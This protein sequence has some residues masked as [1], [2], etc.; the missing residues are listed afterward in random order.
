MIVCI[1]KLAAVRMLQLNEHGPVSYPGFGTTKAETRAML[2]SQ[3]NP[4]PTP[5]EEPFRYPRAQTTQILAD[6]LQTQLS[7]PS[8][9]QAA[10][11][12]GVPHTTLHYWQQRRQR[13]NAP[14]ERIA[15]F[16]SPAGLAFLKQFLL[17]LHLVFQQHGIA[18]IRPLC[19]F[20]ELS[21]LAP[22]VAS[23]YGSQQQLAT[24]LQQLLAQYDLEQRQALAPTMTAKDITLCE[25]ENFHGEQP[26]LVAIEPL[27][28][29]LVLETY[30]PQRDADTWNKVV[31]AALE[32]LP[33]RVIQVTS[34]LAKGLQAHARDG[35][36][37]QHTPDLMHV[38][39][40]LHK[41]TSLPLHRYLENA[42]E[43]LPQ[44]QEKVQHWEERYRLHQ[45]NIRSP[46]RSPDFEQSLDWARKARQ[47]WEQQVAERQACQEEVQAAVRGLGDD[48]HP[49]DAQTGQAVSVEQMQ[50]RLEQRFDTIE[51][52]AD[53][54]G[55]PDSGREK[56]AKAR[57]VSCPAWCGSGTAFACWW[58]RWIWRNRSNKRLPIICCPVCTGQRPRSGAAQPRIGNGC[59]DW[60]R[61]VWRRR[62]RL[63]ESWTVWNQS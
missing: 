52:L 24:L 23:S 19:R 29:F 11:T 61:V 2:A 10:Q 59:G 12:A 50:R 48:Y 44:V 7:P 41:A 1:V 36:Q 54:A 16:D 15:F 30:R 6:C 35:L 62:G 14:L 38:Q 8:T 47:Y 4:T 56:L 60:R 25:D 22:F 33:V 58:S 18:G 5:T 13:I 63:V 17:A 40:D 43:Q 39:S 57:R 42:K 34:D 27:S 26:C 21:Q 53:Q 51:R 55:V 20:L 45:A 37:A 49:F 46:G 31:G 32:G 28:N 9:R 3:H